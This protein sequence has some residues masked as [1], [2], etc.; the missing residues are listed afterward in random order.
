M[1]AIS[2]FYLFLMLHAQSTPNAM[3]STPEITIRLVLPD[4]IKAGSQVKG[5]LE[6]ANTGDKTVQLVSPNYNAALNLV[7]FDNLWDQVSATSLDKAHFAQERFELSSGQTKNLQLDDLTFTTG[8]ARMGYALKPGVYYIMAVYHPGTG[9]LP[10][11]GAYPVAVS[12][13]VK[14]LVVE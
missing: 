2:C 9:K 4:G 7:V 8:T 5:T 13:N 1:E 10:E 12:S 11:E 14:K 6:I 3:T